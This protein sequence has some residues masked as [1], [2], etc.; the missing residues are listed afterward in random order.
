M[1]DI[2]PVSSEITGEAVTKEREFLVG[3]TQES[4][5]KWRISAGSAPKLR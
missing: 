4:L 1:S 3:T 5:G 2:T